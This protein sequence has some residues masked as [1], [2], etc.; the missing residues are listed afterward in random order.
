[1]NFLFDC[2]AGKREPLSKEYLGRLKKQLRS[3]KKRAISPVLLDG[4]T[5]V[6]EMKEEERRK[7]P[8]GVII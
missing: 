3:G 1:M 2:S 7:W 8:K 5:P 4:S 6:D